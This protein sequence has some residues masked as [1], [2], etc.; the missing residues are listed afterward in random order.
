MS[1]NEERKVKQEYLLP[2]ES[3]THQKQQNGEYFKPGEL[4]T[5]QKPPKKE[6]LKPGLP[7]A[8][9]PRDPGDR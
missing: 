7:G 4:P 2:G 1:K 3:P 5:H 9:G 6:Y 8:G